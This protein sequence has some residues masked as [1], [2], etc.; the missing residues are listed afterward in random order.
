MIK[1]QRHIVHPFAAFVMMDRHGND[2]IITSI[3]ISLDK[4]LDK[5]VLLITTAWGGKSLAVNF[6]PPSS[7]LYRPSIKEI[8]N[9][10]V[11]TSESVGHYYRKMIQFIRATLKDT[12]SIRKTVPGYDAKRGYELAGFVWFQG[13]ND[14]CN[15][16]HLE[17]YTDNMIHFIGDVRRQLDA[18]HLPFLVGILGVYGTDPDSRKFDKWLPASDF[19]K[20]QFAAVEQYDRKSIRAE[21]KLSLG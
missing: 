20:T 10:Q 1:I 6:R 8:E 14:M 4:A 17:Q 11:P 12:E 7:G 3:G 5:P 16:H 2:P 21:A 19:R 13:W 15:R 18:P 9:G